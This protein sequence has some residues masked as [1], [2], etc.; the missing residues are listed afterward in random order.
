MAEKK[1]INLGK[2]VPEK[3]V[4]YWTEEDKA[5]IVQSVLD[6][7]PTYDGGVP[8]GYTVTFMSGSAV[9]ASLSVVS[10]GYIN[11]P[12]KPEKEGYTFIGWVDS[13]GDSVEFPYYPTEDLTLNASYASYASTFVLGFTG[14]TNSSGK[15]T[16]TDDVA[17]F[18]A[19]STATSGIYVSVL[20]PLD[21]V[22]PYNQITEFEDSSGNVFVK[23]PKFWMKWVT[24]GS[25]VIDGWKISNAQAD[26]D[27]FIPDAFLS[28][29]GDYNDYF[30]LGKYEMSGSSAQG[31]SKSGKTCLV[32]ITRAN[33]RAAARAYGS[34]SNSYNGYQQED[35]AMLTV[36]NFLCMMYYGTANI[37]TVYG[38]R[39]GSESS[40]SSASVTGTCD[41][42]AG[43]NGWNTSA[44]CVKMLGIENPFGNIYKW[45]DGIFFSGSMV[46]YQQYPQNFADSAS[47]ATALGFSRPTSGGYVSALKH[48][49][50]D[51]T[52]SCAY[53]SAVSG[54][55]SSYYGDY[56]WSGGAMLGV[57]GSWS[58]PSYAGLW[59]LD[60]N[61][62]AS[63][64]YS[65]VGA[66]LSYRP[67]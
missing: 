44:N 24:D 48:G 67:L 16:L 43:M 41:G 59:F 52:R 36:Y 55:A 26:E 18:G 45:I 61:D 35:I 63:D 65:S 19:Y 49:T 27:Y 37:Q 10:G 56:S 28:P 33:A 34:E 30:A 60:G 20:N 62:S 11:A 22:F 6:A 8:G 14:L 12:S 4:D 25:G 31:Y 42:V 54:S 38:G 29:N 1:Q 66:R 23:F 7:L 17:G 9:Y 58:D 21:D 57:G 13:N 64:S 50:A 53:A 2:V 51:N 15:L 5:E 32:N 3:G 47:N 46:Y 39:T 40:W